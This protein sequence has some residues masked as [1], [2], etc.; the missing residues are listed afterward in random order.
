MGYRKPSMKSALG[1]TKA[2]RRINKASGKSSVTKILNA[3][4]NT[5]RKIKRKAGYY[6]TPMKTIRFISRLLK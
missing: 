3:P 1:I 5:K 4:K 2:K 6:S